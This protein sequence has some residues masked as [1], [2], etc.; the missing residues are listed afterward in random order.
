PSAPPW[1]A[2]LVCFAGWTLVSAAFSTDPRAGFADSKQLVLLLIVPIT[3]DVVD[4]G[5]ALPLSTCLL[6][7]AAVSAIVGIGQYS[8]LHYDTLGLR[9]RGTLGHWMTFSGLMMLALDV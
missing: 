4:E 5:R 9:V 3:F 7:A 8:I 6:G 1:A 2:A